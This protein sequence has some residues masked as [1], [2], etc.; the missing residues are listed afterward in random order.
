MCPNYHYCEANECRP[1]PFFKCWYNGFDLCVF[2]DGLVRFL[3]SILWRAAESFVSDFD[4]KIH[5]SAPCELAGMM[6][7]L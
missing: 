5:V 3:L 6:H 1:I 7:W 2:S 4:F